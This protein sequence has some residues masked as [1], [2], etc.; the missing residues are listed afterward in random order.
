MSSPK[1]STFKLVVL[2]A[3]R[4]AGAG[5]SHKRCVRILG[6]EKRGPGRSGQEERGT[7]R[8]GGSG[9]EWRGGADKRRRMGA[10]DTAVGTDSTRKRAHRG[11]AAA[12]WRHTRGGTGI[13]PHDKGARDGARLVARTSLLLLFPCP[14]R[15]DDPQRVAPVGVLQEGGHISV[16]PHSPQF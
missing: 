4:R 8:R 7:Q 10:W 14:H 6:A 12:T 5:D 2:P 9:R 1:K 16:W 13:G 3:R 11:S 15:R